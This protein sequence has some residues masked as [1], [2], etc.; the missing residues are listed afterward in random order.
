MALSMSL[1]ALSIDAM[2]PALS[3]IAGE[4][5]VDRENDRQLVLTVLFIG[6]ALGQIFYGPIS[7]S[8]G[9]RSPIYFGFALFVVGSVIAA[10]SQSY[11]WLL[12]GRFLQGLGAAGP[13]ILTV[14]I[15][16]DH[17]SG[18]EMAR[19]MSLVM[20]VFILVPAIAPAL[21]QLIL[22][23]AHW[24]VIFAALVV[25][26][27]LTMIWFFLRQP[28]TLAVQDRRKFSLI[29]I[30][31]AV[32]EIFHNSA[33][34]MYTLAGGMVFGAFVGFLNSSQQI[35]QELYGLGSQ[36]PT[37]FAILA[38]SLGVASWI[39][40]QLVV[41]LGMRLLCKVALCFI[42]LV[43]LVFLIICLIMTPSLLMVMSYLMISFFAIGLLFGNLNALAMEPLG[44]IAGLASSLIGSVTTLV[45]LSLGYLIGAMYDHT[46]IPL[47]SGFGLLSIGALGMMFLVKNQPD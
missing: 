33:A 45:S 38:L 35:L 25:L 2:L 23:F 19:I 1:V 47:V 31:S 17:A 40:S 44:H 41:R 43:A 10:L 24:R 7:D 12:C 16:R 42:A 4:L 30:W 6:L 26:A 3:Q 29:S 32:V 18:R 34:V 20:M 27:I 36:F 22:S 5:G 46:L 9:R 39:N 11:W 15:I 13:R 8:F 37:Y 14:A 28:E 21:G